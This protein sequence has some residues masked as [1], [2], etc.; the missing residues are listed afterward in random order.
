MTALFIYEFH[1]LKCPITE[2]TI[3]GLFS[4]AFYCMGTGKLSN[5]IL[6]GF[7]LFADFINEF[8]H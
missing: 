6:R 2:N 5:E 7:L 3:K 8:L 4:E 1:S